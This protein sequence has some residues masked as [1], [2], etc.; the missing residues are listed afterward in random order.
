MAITLKWSGRRY[1]VA[2]LLFSVTCG[3]FFGSLDAALAQGST[4]NEPPLYPPVVRQLPDGAG[5]LSLG[6]W[7]LYPTLNFHSF[8]D[9]NIYSSPTSP[10]STAGVNFNPSLLALYDT[11]IHTTS[12]YGNISSNIYPFIDSMNDTFDRQAGFTEKYEA[13]RDL[14]FT[15]QGNYQ[16]STNA[17]VFTQALPAPLLS[18]ASPALPGLRVSSL[19]NRASLIPTT[20]IPQQARFI[21]S[22]I[23]PS[24]R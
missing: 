11:G 17:Y 20:P 7:L 21:K 19:R 1:R 23:A 14:I 4:T 9:T 6:D 8:Y 22:S 24:W 5:T 12:L 18:P 2:A 3:C 15:L 13:M 16:H 10:I